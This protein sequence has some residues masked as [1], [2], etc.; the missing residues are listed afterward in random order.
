M[1]LDSNYTSCYDVF[2]KRRYSMEI[3]NKEETNMILEE[4]RRLEEELLKEREKT[5]EEFSNIIKSY[6]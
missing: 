1:T 5:E 4:M 2:H 6:S 3:N